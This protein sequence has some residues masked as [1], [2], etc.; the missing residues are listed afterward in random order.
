MKAYAANTKK[1]MKLTALLLLIQLVFTNLSTAQAPDCIS[2]TVMYGIFTNVG[3]STTADSTDIRPITYA[4]GAV[5]NLMGN[6]RYWIRKQLSGVWYYGAS[7]MGLNPANGHFYVNT[8]MSGGGGTKDFIAINTATGAMSIIGMTPATLNDYHFVKMAVAPSGL[9]YAIG[10]HRDS[11]AAA[12]TCNPLVRFSTCGLAPAPG[13]A[14]GTIQVLGYLPSTALMYKWDLFNGD[15]SFDA[16]GNMYFATAAFWR[17]N[18]L[19]RYTDARLF[20][21]N[22]ADIPAVPGAGTIPMSLVAEYNGLDSTVVNGLTFDPAGSLYISTRRFLGVQASPAPPSVSEVYTS[23]TMGSSNNLATFGP[24][25]AGKSMGDLAGCYFPAMVLALNDVRL[26]GKYSGGQS[27]LRW[28]SHN[29]NNVTY[30]EIQ[31]SEN[32]EDFETIARVNPINVS[33]PNQAYSYNDADAGSGRRYYRV[34][35]VLANGGR[36]YSNVIN[37]NVSA[38]ITLT[39][40]I[41]PNPIESFFDVNVK[42]TSTNSVLIRLVDQNGRVVLTQ[43]FT[44]NG[45]DNKF[46]VNNLGKLTKGIYIAEIS[47]DED[48]IREKINQAIMFYRL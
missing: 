47:V 37:I 26:S 28:E 8:Q 32:G 6:R 12:A 38:K 31:R 20:R 1:W 30:Y 33:Q 40:R 39:G 2:G 14:T 16:V 46:T 3:G 7:A 27:T 42:L 24:V 45:G 11:S 13:C 35:Q 17:V 41:R 23:W 21:V 22:A 10:V 29:N 44:G 43:R 48:I 4:T 5:G 18:G 9:G 25:P 36:Y 19:G 15:I 34:R